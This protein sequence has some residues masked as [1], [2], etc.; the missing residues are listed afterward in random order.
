V[1]D[2]FFIFNFIVIRVKINTS[3]TGEDKFIIKY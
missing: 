1:D 3:Q 2:H